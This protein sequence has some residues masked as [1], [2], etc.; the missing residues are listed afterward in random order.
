MTGTR[1]RKYPIVLAVVASLICF[2]VGYIAG[3]QTGG[4]VADRALH[5]EINALAE[6]E[7]YML[8]DDSSPTDWE[9]VEYARRQGLTFQDMG[10]NEIRFY[11]GRAGRR[12]LL[13][14]IEGTTVLVQ[15]R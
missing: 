9:V 2:G 10:S 3:W 4:N 6:V 1:K 8:T 14:K 13:L 7:R 5:D 11:S 15:R 12:T